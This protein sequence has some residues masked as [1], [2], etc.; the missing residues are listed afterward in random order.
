MKTTVK[1]EISSF[2]TPIDSGRECSTRNSIF[3]ASCREPKNNSFTINDDINMLI[4]EKIRYDFKRKY[5]QNTICALSKHTVDTL[6][7]KN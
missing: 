7:E 5:R 3:I 6:K 2:S 1:Y 4:A